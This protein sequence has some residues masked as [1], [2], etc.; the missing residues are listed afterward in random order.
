MLQRVS[1]EQGMERT[2]DLLPA[3]GAGRQ[4]GWQL[5]GEGSNCWGRH[6]TWI[7]LFSGA[8]SQDNFARV[9]QRQHR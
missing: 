7:Q 4:G 1:S 5:R 3:A 9:M 2:E 8:M 6:T